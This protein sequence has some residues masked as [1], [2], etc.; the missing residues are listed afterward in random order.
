MII[1]KQFEEVRKIRLKYNLSIKDIE[2]ILKLNKMKDKIT[3][4]SKMK[5]LLT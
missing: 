2:I 5:K 3:L 1:N 4:T